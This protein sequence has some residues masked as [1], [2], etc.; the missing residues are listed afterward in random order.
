MTTTLIQLSDTH[1][2]HQRGFFVENFQAAIA[3]LDY[4]TLKENGKYP[5][6]KDVPPRPAEVAWPP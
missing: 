5:F 1:L 2:S 6:L 3:A 4:N